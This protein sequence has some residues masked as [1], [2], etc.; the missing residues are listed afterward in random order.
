MEMNAADF[1]AISSA[2]GFVAMDRFAL[3]G[4]ILEALLRTVMPIPEN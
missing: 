3:L 4:D 2:R 1:L